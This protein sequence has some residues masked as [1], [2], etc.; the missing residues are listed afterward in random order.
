MFWGAFNAKNLTFLNDSNREENKHT[1][2]FE[3]IS[4][5]N[6]TVAI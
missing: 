5:R 1:N 3:K 2:L 4:L 6:D